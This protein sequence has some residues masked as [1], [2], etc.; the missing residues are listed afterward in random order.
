MEWGE[1]HMARGEIRKRSVYLLVNLCKL[2]VPRCLVE[3]RSEVKAV[4]VR[5]V[6]LCVICWCQHCELVTI[7]GIAAKEVLH[8]L[9]NLPSRYIA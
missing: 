7:H 5:A 6:A 2:P 4:V 3:E 1:V 9:S 8:F